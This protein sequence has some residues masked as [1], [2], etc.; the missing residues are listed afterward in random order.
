LEHSPPSWAQGGTAHLPKLQ[1]GVCVSH[2]WPQLPQL[3]GSFCSL[4]HVEPQHCS[5]GPHAGRQVTPPELLPELPPLLP[6][7]APLLDPLEPLDPPDEL[8]LLLPPSCP[9]STE[10]SFPPVPSVSLAPPH[11]AKTST[12]DRRLTL[13][14]K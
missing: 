6:E 8:P 14:T 10:A 12:S 2:L 5:N 1:Y 13:P 7:L 11:L 3:V 4:T 9:P